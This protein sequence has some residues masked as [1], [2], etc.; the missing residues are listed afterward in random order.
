MFRFNNPDALLVLLLVA[1]AYAIVARDRGRAGTRWLLLAGVARRLRLPDQ[2]A[3]GV[4]RPPAARAGV[5]GRRADA[6]CGAASASCCARGAAVVVSG[7]WWVALVELWPAP[8]RP[9]IGGS[10]TNSRARADPRLQRP[11]PHH[12]RRGP[13]GRAA[14]RAAAASAACPREAWAVRVVRRGRLRR[15]AGCPAPVH[16][17]VLRP[18]VLAPARGAR[19]ARRR[20]L[21]PAPR[22]AHRPHPRSPAARRPLDARARRGLQR[23]QRDH[24]PLLRGRPGPRD[25]AHDRRRDVPCC[26]DRRSQLWTR[27]V[28]AVVVAGTALW[29]RGDPH[30]ARVDLRGRAGCCSSPG[31]S[32]RWRCSSRRARW[33]RTATVGVLA[34]LVAVLGGSTAF[35]A[36]TAVTPHQGSIVSAGPARRDGHARRA[37]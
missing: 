18:G 23:D 30:P 16:V 24:P 9:Y 2:D 3:A 26:G 34:A 19:A 27:V 22:A 31:C 10:Q 20:A 28:L 11:R 14:A 29:S 5:P 25:R 4:P 37:P 6:A 35:A 33:G 32:A 13:G 8:S 21:G 1:A 17:R 36:D 7:G 12:R 15:P